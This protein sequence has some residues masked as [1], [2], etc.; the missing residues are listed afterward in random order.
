VSPPVSHP[1][2]AER[3]RALLETYGSRVASWPVEV[4]APAQVFIATSPQAAQWLAQ[5]RELDVWLDSATGVEPSPALLR[6]IAEI[7]LRH[8]QV[9]WWARWNPRS[10]IAAL[11]AAAALGVL[12]GVFIPDQSFDESDTV[13]ESDTADD[14]F[15]LTWNADV[16]DEAVP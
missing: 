11:T 8:P 14:E 4:Q 5:Q 16:P 12:A 3:F 10:A 2:T 13:S 15:A 6:R 9:S 1:L 7:P